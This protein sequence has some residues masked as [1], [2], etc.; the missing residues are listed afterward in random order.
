LGFLRAETEMWEED[1]HFVGCVVIGEG[2]VCVRFVSS[3]DED[4]GTVLV[5]S[6]LRYDSKITCEF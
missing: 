3:Y 1:R 6:G 4:A 2:Y 5:L